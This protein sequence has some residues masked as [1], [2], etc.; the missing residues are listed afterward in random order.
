MLKLLLKK[1][2]SEI[3][4][5]YFY[6]AKKNKAR[7][8]GATAGFIVMFVVL[9]AVV[10]GGMFA[11][12]CALIYPVTEENN[13]TWLYFAVTGVTAV[14]LGCFGSVFNTYSGLYLSKDNDLLLSMPIKVRDII[15]SRVAGV[16]IIGLMYSGVVTVPAATVSIVMGKNTVLSVAGAIL[17]ILNV[18]LIVLALSCILGWVVAKVSLKLKNKSFITVLIS[19]V[20]FALYYVVCF[21]ANEL[22]TAF[23]EN[24]VAYGETI[25]SSVY[26]LYICGRAGAGAPAELLSVTAGTVLIVL[27]V[28]TVI[29]RSFIKIAT[30]TGKQARVKYNGKSEKVKSA[31]GA[32]LAREFEHL[33][34]SPNYMLNCALGAV[35]FPIVGIIFIVKADMLRLLFSEVLSPD[36]GPILA[37][38]AAFAI[39]STVGTA[40]PSVSL[41][42]KTLW[43]IRSLPVKSE[44]VLKAKLKVQLWISVIPA[45]VFACLAAV[46]FKT[47]LLT[48][49]AFALCV[50]A[51]TVFMGVVCMLLALNKPNLNWTSEIIAIKQN[52]NVLFA[53]LLG[54]AS[55][56]VF[57]LPYFAVASFIPAP[58]YMAAFAVAFGL[59]AWALYRKLMKNGKT[60]FEAL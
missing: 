27:L 5:S 1:Q 7:S 10:L 8:K 21:R 49:I 58:L 19:L 29:S 18:S 26:P 37:C 20:F 42:G 35:I 11:A 17:N 56:I 30:S 23:V 15:M 28:G 41:E 14:M 44:N 48:A 22:I 57:A 59:I 12:F 47:E 4:R 13:I 33:K 54:V 31:D 45:A 6:D 16:Y 3:F 50:I 55:A 36:F 40:I 24:A 51:Y 46:A 60:V 32:L 34:S 39:A 2:M 25:M 53:M 43:L 38:A 52:I 9:M